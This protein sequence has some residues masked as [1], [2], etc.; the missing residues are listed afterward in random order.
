MSNDHAGGV[1]PGARV[2]MC[3]ALDPTT[4]TAGAT[5]SVNGSVIDRLA[6]EL[7]RGVGLLAAIQVLATLATTKTLTVTAKLQHGD[8]SDLS[9]AA[10]FGD[11]AAVDVAASGA[12]ITSTDPALVW[13]QS[14]DV[15]GDIR[16]MKRYCRVVVSGVFSNTGTDTAV[17]AAT[18]A[19]TGLDEAPGTNQT[20]LGAAA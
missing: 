17:V 16:T 6:A 4:L 8:E 12:L 9:D 10:D 15:S 7:Q 11:W 5:I 14:F 20:A 1:D 18:V 2:A 19:F 13:R 3:Y